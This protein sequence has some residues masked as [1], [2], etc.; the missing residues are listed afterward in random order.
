MKGKRGIVG[1]NSVFNNFAWKLAERTSSQGVSFVVSVVLA[2]ILLPEEFGVI[3][4]IQIFI[5]FAQCFI[6]SGFSSS[7]IQKKDADDLDFST[8]FYCSLV[9]SLVL[10]V[11]L[12]FCSPL[13]ADFYN[14][15]LL[16]DV[17]RVYGITLLISAYNSIQQAWVARHMRFK[18]MFYSTLIGNIISGIAGIILAYCGFGVW[19]LVAQVI[20]SLLIN[21]IVLEVLI[22]WSPK[23][24]FSFKRAR[25]LM[26]YGSNILG[27]SLIS[28]LYFQ[29]RQLLIGKFYNAT[30]LAFYNRGLQLPEVVG[31][32][33]DDSLGQVLFPVLSNFS[34]SPA[35]VKDLT[36]RAMQVTSY[37]LFFAMSLML[38]IAEPL[39]RVLL[40]DKWIECVP[41]FQITCLTVMLRT[42]SNSNLQS[43]K[44]VGRSDIVL[45]L[46]IIKKPVG[47]L[48]IIL[49][50]KISVLA[51]AITAPVYGLYSAFVNMSYNK[52]ILGYTIKEQFA[53]LRPAF[54]LCC[55]MLCVTIPINLL[56]I[57][58]YLKIA[59]TLMI[60]MLIYISFSI[61]FQVKSFLYIKDIIKNTIKSSRK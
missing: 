43:Y 19:A 18:L 25:P 21:T 42:I 31:S 10:Y 49:A 51:L 54:L 27:S 45:K 6:V 56:D 8:I 15:P 35:T 61:L 9:V 13:I 29:L 41:Y 23:L 37:A 47:F 1:S 17:T 48:L 33:L 12:F 32:N 11:A 40:T 52:N 3:A 30:D 26:I 24:V 59:F 4:M 28:T 34:N 46:E 14:L 53:D 50:F 7:L 39:I 36:R 5:L 38:T 58:D 20:F 60:G 2:R 22:D 55:L 44:A 16:E 57:S